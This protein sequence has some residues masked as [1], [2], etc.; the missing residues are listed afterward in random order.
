MVFAFFFLFPILILSV[1][2]LTGKDASGL[3]KQI[4]HSLKKEIIKIIKNHFLQI[5]GNFEQISPDYIITKVQMK[6]REYYLIH[7]ENRKKTKVSILGA[8]L[9]LI[10]VISFHSSAN[11]L[12]MCLTFTS[13]RKAILS[14][15]CNFC[16]QN[17]SRTVSL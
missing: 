7:L 3:F 16:Q 9:V 17:Q 11:T 12:V 14:F 5:L 15:F 13:F 4:S 8:C 10:G 2:I 1:V 6:S